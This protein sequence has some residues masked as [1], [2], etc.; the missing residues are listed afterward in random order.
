MYVGAV[1]LL[2]CITVYCC[3]VRFTLAATIQCEEEGNMLEAGGRPEKDLVIL[4]FQV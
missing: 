4:L 3:L 2:Y 1:P